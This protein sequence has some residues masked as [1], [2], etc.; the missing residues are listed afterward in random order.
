VFVEQN[1]KQA[2]AQLKSLK[3]EAERLRSR[4]QKVDAGIRR[5]ETL[6]EALRQ[7]ERISVTDPRIIPQVF[8]PVPA[9][10]AIEESTPVAAA[11]PGPKGHKDWRPKREVSGALA[12]REP[13]PSPPFES[14]K[15]K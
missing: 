11:G 10:G 12:P 4:L 8:A 1:R 9:P 7:S 14:S 6:L 15:P 3:D 5:W 13:E 2:E